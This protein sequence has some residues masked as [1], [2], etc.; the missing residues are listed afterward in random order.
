MQFII[1]QI[2]VD[3]HETISANLYFKAQRENYM[4]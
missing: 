4:V 1:V 2:Y 3:Q